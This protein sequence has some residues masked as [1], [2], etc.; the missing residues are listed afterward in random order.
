MT[1]N[2]MNQANAFIVADV[3]SAEHATI[4]VPSSA[5]VLA[6]IFVKT[7]FRLIKSNTGDRFR[8]QSWSGDEFW[9]KCVFNI[10]MATCYSHNGLARLPRSNDGISSHSCLCRWQTRNK[11]VCFSHLLSMLLL[12]LII[13]R[14]FTAPVLPNTLNS[15]TTSRSFTCHT[16]NRSHC[17][18]PCISEDT[19]HVVHRARV[20]SRCRTTPLN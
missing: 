1:S 19:I 9:R 8:R 20:V 3:P 5:P 10:A 2:C 7:L 16:A 15:G 17:E 12:F 6:V 13:L 11:T 14:Q 4:P 18:P